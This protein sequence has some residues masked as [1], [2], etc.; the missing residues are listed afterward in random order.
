MTRYYCLAL[1]LG[2]SRLLAADVS[3]LTQHNDLR[4]T[5][6]NLHEAILNTANVN[7][8]S[9]GLIGTREVDDQLYAQPLVVSGVSV[10]GVGKRTLLIA[11]T[12]NDSV[13]AFDADN[14]ATSAPYWKVSFLGPNAVAPTAA[15]M[16][17]AC[18]G[19][20]KDFSGNIGIVGSPVI[21]P[22]SDTLYLV[23]RTK[24]YG[25]NCVQRLHALD[26]RTGA[27][28]EHS[29]V[30]IKATCPGH[31]DGHRDGVLSFDPQ[32]ANQRAGLALVN[33]IVFIGWSSHCDWG[34]YHGWLLGYDMK[35]LQRVATYNTTPEG[36]NGGIWMS[37]QGP[38]ADDRGNL[39]L[40][41]GNGSVGAQGNPRDPVNRGESLLRLQ[42]DGK[43]L[44]LTD[45]FTPANWQDLENT[46][47]DFGNSGVLLIPGTTLAFCGSKEGKVYLV[48]YEQ[49][50]GLSHSAQDT[51]IVQ[52]FQVSSPGS[53]FGLFAAPV[54]WD[55]PDASW[56]Y[57][58]CKEDSLRQYKFERGSGK[59]VL[60]E[61]ARSGGGRRARMPGGVLA[62]S[63]NGKQG[64]SGIVWA[65]HSLN[66]DANHVVAPGILRAFRAADVSVE[67]WNSEQVKTRD[68]VGRF[69]KFCPP[70]IANGKV[71][72]AT[73]SN[74]V[75]IYGL[76]SGGR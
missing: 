32:R 10:P 73:F 49:M 24:E 66:S 59:F 21:D 45:W 17:G 57:L 55:G 58:W 9:F 8:N 30:E 40:S 16:D 64:D 25:T 26:I 35:T 76:L 5:G 62:V 28:R 53:S 43:L 4:R 14:A 20:Y 1:L 36:Y 71:Y 19:D 33:G 60:P 52:S 56:A 44:H 12:V 22:A 7:T 69:A 3:V 15:D 31:G 39:Y 27:E 48:N 46:D 67:L 72:L 13:Y 2:S 65:S 63:A 37:G 68:A 42:W 74:R 38:A 51:N 47:N 50:G 34:P 70:V 18:G 29:P 61:C 41:V 75:D 6:A 11:A 54:W 23:A